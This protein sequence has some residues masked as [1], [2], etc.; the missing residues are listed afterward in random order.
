MHFDAGWNLLTLPAD[1]ASAFTAQSLLDAVN[2]QGG[3][4][5][6][7]DRWI[8]YWDPH[9]DALPTTNNF[10][11]A[12]GA[13]YFVRC[14]APSDWTVDG[15]SL[16]APIPLALSSGWNLIG[17]PYPSSGYT[18]QS[19][20]ADIT[21]Q[22]GTCSEIDNWEGMWVAHLQVLPTVNNFAILRDRG[23]FVRCSA[24]S[25]FTPGE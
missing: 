22:G 16:S 19:V 24:T 4:C 15:D 17:I 3:A 1:P 14:S 5:S 25:S 11:L 18:A 20:L 8:G 21:S 2:A 23:Y 12:L 6:E 13:G 9:L 10:A 7:I